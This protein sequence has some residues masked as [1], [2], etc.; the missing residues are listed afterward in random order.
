MSWHKHT[1]RRGLPSD[2]QLIERYRNIWIS[3]GG[4]PD[5]TTAD[6][7]D[8]AITS[9]FIGKRAQWIE[10]KRRFIIRFGEQYLY[11]ALDV[12]PWV[13]DVSMTAALLYTIKASTRVMIRTSVYTLMG[14]IGIYSAQRIFFGVDRGGYFGNPGPGY[15]GLGMAMIQYPFGDEFSP[16]G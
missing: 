2:K 7:L 8:A 1:Y 4:S 13:V 5:I 15:F 12:D 11:K 6:I 16:E 9:D 3:Q 14:V 10:M